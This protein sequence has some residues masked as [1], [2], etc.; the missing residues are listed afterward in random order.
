M[1]YTAGGYRFGDFARMGLPM[2][3]LVGSITCTLAP[4]VY[5]F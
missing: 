5:G 1:V 4:L 3:L 2:T